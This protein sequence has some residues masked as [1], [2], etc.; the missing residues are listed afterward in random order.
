MSSISSKMDILREKQRQALED[1]TLGVFCPRCRKKNPLKEFPLDKVEVCQF[2]ELDHD[3]KEFPSLPQVKVSLDA[4]TP[5]VELAY[6]IA[7][8]KPWKPQNQGMNPD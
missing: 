7:Q 3:M 2:F 4:S 5:D 6:F 1:L 8:K